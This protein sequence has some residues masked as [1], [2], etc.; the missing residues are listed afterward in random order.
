M[1]SHHR[2]VEQIVGHF[3]T[4][5]VKFFVVKWKGEPESGNSFETI[6]N[7]QEDIHKVTQ[8]ERSHIEK[9]NRRRDRDYYRNTEQ[10]KRDYRESKSDRQF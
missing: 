6:D 1:S 9:R 8:Y 2:K 5:G 3:W 7:L 10:K 4:G